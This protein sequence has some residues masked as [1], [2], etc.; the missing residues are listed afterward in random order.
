MEQVLPGKLITSVK[1][2]HEKSVSFKT[3]TELVNNNKLTRPPFQTDLNE[4]KVEE[5]IESY[6]KHPE[7]L[8]FKNKIIIVITHKNWYVVDGQ[9]RI[10]MAKKLMFY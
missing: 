10:E 7:F 9:H 4:N 8:I 3:I 6:I 1:N 2:C 5:M